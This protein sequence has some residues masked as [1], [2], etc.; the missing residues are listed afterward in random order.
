MIQ[1]TKTALLLA[2]T[3]AIAAPALAQ[4]P[5]EAQR[6]AIKSN[7]RSDYMAHCSSIPPGGAAS[8]QCLQKNMA[9][10]SGGLRRRG[11]GGGGSQPRPRRSLPAAPKEEP[12]ETK[13]EPAP[14]AEPAKPAAAEP[15]AKASTKA[16]ATTPGKPSS[17][18]ISGDPRQL[19]LRLSQG[20]RGCADRRRGGAGM[21]GKEQ[22]KTLGRLRKGGC[23]G[24]RRQRG[25]GSKQRGACASQRQRSSRR[26]GSCCRAGSAGAAADA[27]ARSAVR[28]ALGLRRRRARALR[29][30]ARG[31]RPHHRMPR[32]AAGGAV[33]GLPRRVGAVRRAI[34]P[35]ANFGWRRG[36]RGARVAQIGSILS[37]REDYPCASP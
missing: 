1:N 4:A 16:A 26:G 33:A 3:F 10:L 21:P 13:A 28:G 32:L 2:A 7:C 11:E 23:R 6:A 34:I 20:L 31:R 17:A 22:G 30:R 24:R 29:R 12:K 18:Q 14:A 27:A 36:C 37:I 15:A 8:L 9:S 35:P 19:P 5:S 25:A